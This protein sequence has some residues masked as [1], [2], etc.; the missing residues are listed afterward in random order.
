M[1][2][3]ILL[4][5]LIN[6]LY[7]KSFEIPSIPIEKKLQDPFLFNLMNKNIPLYFQIDNKYN[8]FKE[9]FNSNK[10]L[11][12]YK[13]IYEIDD[14]LINK[15]QSVYKKDYINQLIKSSK[16]KYLYHNNINLNDKFS[17]EYTFY[18]YLNYFRYD[19]LYNY[20]LLIPK[21]SIILN[22]TENIN[23]IETDLHKI[24]INF[25]LCMTK[26]IKLKIINPSINNILTINDIKTDLN[27]INIIQDTSI[28]YS[29]HKINYNF[30]NNILPIYINPNSSSIIE[31][32]YLIDFQGITRGTL[33]IKFNDKKVLL[34]PIELKGESNKF[35]IN[36]MYYPFW[37]I[38]NKTKIPITIYNPFNTTLIIKEVHHG[39]NNISLTWANDIPVK[40]NISSISQNMLEI[41]PR[42]KKNIMYVKYERNVFDYEYNILTLRTEDDV[43]TIPILFAT[44]IGNLTFFP[45]YINFG[46][47]NILPNH[48]ENLIKKVKIYVINNGDENIKINKIYN[49]YD[50]KY[51]N[52]YFFN[53]NEKEI[54]IEKQK[55]IFLGYLV[56]NAQN[57]NDLNN[58]NK[59]IIQKNIYIETNETNFFY[60]INYS[61][62]LDNGKIQNYIIDKAL[63]LYNNKNFN[64]SINIKLQQPYGIEQNN[65]VSSIYINEIKN[66]LKFYYDNPDSIYNL[67]D[68]NI[69][70]EY[71]ENNFNTIN[72]NRYYFL[73]IELN[74]RLYSIIPIK[75]NN[76]ELDFLY[77]G[78]EK[79]LINCIESDSKLYYFNILKSENI[80]E[81]D[82]NIDFQLINQNYKKEK[83]FYF[84]NENDYNKT[85]SSINGKFNILK[86]NII[87]VI[88]FD[89]IYD[90][91]FYINKNTDI[92]LFNISLPANS[93][94]K[95]SITVSETINISEFKEDIYFVFDINNNK[96]H[97]NCKGTI[98][99]ET[100]FFTSSII[101]KNGF[102]GLIQVNKI[103]SINNFNFPFKINKIISKDS[104][105]IP[106]LI[107]E[108]LNLNN[109]NID[110]INVIFNPFEKN[111]NEDD[112]K[113]TDLNMN[114]YLT[115]MEL[116]LYKKK[117]KLWE[118]YNNVFEFNSTIT[119][120]TNLKRINININAF[121]IKPVL[122]KKNNYDFGIVQIG[123]TK[124]IFIEIFNPSDFVLTYR[125]MLGSEHLSETDKL[126]MFNN[127][128]KK[129]FEE[130]NKIYIFNCNFIN[131][132][133]N[134]I[135]VNKS[136][137]IIVKE[138]FDDNL[139]SNKIINKNEIIK[140][141]YFYGNDEEKKLLSRSKNILCNYKSTTKND[142]IIDY[143]TNQENKK[144]INQIFSNYFTKEI[145]IIKKMTQNNLNYNDIYNSY[146][147]SFLNF[148]K[149]FKNI[150]IPS[151]L[152]K[153]SSNNF[154]IS[155]PNKKDIQNFY[156]N[157]TYSNKIFTL[158][159]H[160]KSLI[161]PIIF[162]P[163]KSSISK[164]TL[165]IKNNLTIMYPI[166]IKGE[167]GKGEI[168]FN[169]IQNNQKSK[170][171]KFI[172]NNKLIIDID[173]NVY[174]QEIK[175]KSNNI[176][177]T[178]TLS[179]KGNLPLKIK[180]IT[181]NN[182]SCES[183]GLK[184]LQCEQINLN[185]GENIDLD[186]LIIPDFN[187][188][189]NEKEI[190]FYTEYNIIPLKII[191][192]INKSVLNE[193]NFLFQFPVIN[194]NNVFCIFVVT[195]IN[196]LINKLYDLSKKTKT[197]NLGKL[198]F[199]L[200]KINLDIII[201]NL[202]IK[203]SRH[204][205]KN[206]NKEFM[207]QLIDKPG[208]GVEIDAFSNDNK[209]KRK[210]KK[211][212]NKNEN[213]N[214]NVDFEI[215]KNIINDNIIDNKDNNINT[216]NIENQDY[217]NQ[218]KSE[219]EEIKENNNNKNKNQKQIKNININ[220]NINKR[221]S[222][223]NYFYNGL[224]NKRKRNIKNK[225]TYK[226][227]FKYNNYYFD[228]RK[229]S[230]K[231]ENSINNENN[232]NNKEINNNENENKTELENQNN[233]INENNFIN[234]FD[235]EQSNNKKNNSFNNLFND[236]ES[237]NENFFSYNVESNK[238]NC[239][240]SGNELTDKEIKEYNFKFVKFDDY[241]IKIKN[242]FS[243]E[244]YQN[245]K[246]LDEL[247][248]D[249]DET[250]KSDDNNDEV[251]DENNE[252]HHDF[253]QKFDFQNYS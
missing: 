186:I 233:N 136:K 248:D 89:N 214:I 67:Y 168:L 9:N 79:D 208:T 166:K 28:K 230:F 162:H 80:H 239:E 194:V 20:P 56:F 243:N 54:I 73:P 240:L 155:K 170:N 77:C 203:A 24:S 160:Q 27:Q 5:F 25:S 92:N 163:F 141:L 3:R 72:H 146:K 40:I 218:K 65:S 217:K 120:F 30:I 81:Y 127:I 212:L 36:S 200:D 69:T 159:P 46:L 210:Y 47:C 113:F 82:I 143:E 223:D 188:N 157:P 178:F 59:E 11:N 105:I 204:T 7:I 205:N 88:F 189:I 130:N 151:Y 180:N 193:K 95:F 34:V 154:Y 101:F 251:D 235:Y 185:P 131:Y 177:R 112:F 49:D 57:F 124:E 250:I 227:Y 23:E 224:N 148:I 2:L 96:L 44:V 219:E 238:N 190:L 16:N 110:I 99:N 183:Y 37:K 142:I 139:L 195:V 39:F 187:F 76:D 171:T 83:Y 252:N 174:N 213:N 140:K 153:I 93:I 158:Q 50:D 12:D 152:N 116:Y 126:S 229:H 220:I 137:T 71:I 232:F 241:D 78:E 133:N 150:F 55:K 19:L 38:N 198:N 42:S 17:E 1:I 202:Y 87:G 123:Q 94:T 228:K 106:S 225:N 10:Y 201:E 173:H 236:Y 215:K 182:K 86:I 167:G 231:S 114:N 108:H 14:Y 149:K 62:L 18:G 122:F 237:T 147:K 15:Y 207:F 31:L 53:N 132:E 245:N 29:N 246:K 125:V 169:N 103:K 66:Y 8:N 75:F 117:E 102:P 70:V 249:D 209:K 41:S 199:I 52:F 97:F 115:F 242:P 164:A 90:N 60:Y 191:I 211:K 6:F 138:D 21:N 175:N 118:K 48:K 61:Y 134:N 35:K 144:L 43:I 4:F 104:R 119:L 165:I 32:F 197:E 91:N 98:I 64:F 45:N 33:Y 184:I 179:N 226:N 176:T 85:I 13:Q 253:N 234:T 58:I 206:I 172:E 222:Y 196:Q 68:I 145:P 156:L 51:V 84:I 63:N 244:T 192:N 109:N 216:N 181:I 128:D 22:K 135:I 129:Q 111:L 221:T 107:S 26:A 247:I 161:G 74:R 100:L 121:I